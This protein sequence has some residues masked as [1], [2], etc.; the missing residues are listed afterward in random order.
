MAKMAK[1]AAKM[2]KNNV[3]MRLAHARRFWHE[4]INENN[5]NGES[6]NGAAAWRILINEMT[7][8][9]QRNISS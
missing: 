8:G 4:I 7:T 2:A 9:H 5:E 3:S 1:Q 6:A